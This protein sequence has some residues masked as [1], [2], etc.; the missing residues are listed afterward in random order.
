[1]EW[2]P[3]GIHVRGQESPTERWPV[4]GELGWWNEEIQDG[5]REMGLSVGN[6]KH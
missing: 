5:V 4:R 6:S 3:W 1:M 2:K